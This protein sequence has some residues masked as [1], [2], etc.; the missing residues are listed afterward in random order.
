MNYRLDHIPKT[1]SCNR[2]SGL[3][4]TPTTIT[5]HNTGN[6][7]S[8][9]KNER[10]WLTNPENNRTASYHIVVDEH[11]A[12]E[13]IPLNE[14]AWHAGDGSNAAS[15]NRTSIAI[16]ICESGK[17]QQTLHNAAHLVAKM[18]L[19]RGWG[20]ERLRRHFDWSG[21]ICPRLMYD[22]GKWT[23][24]CSFIGMVKSYTSKNEEQTTREVL[25]AVDKLKKTVEEQNKRLKELEG[26]QEID[27]PTW[28]KEAADYYEKEMSNK[29]GSYDFWR[30]LTI[31]YRKKVIQHNEHGHS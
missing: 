24:W 5:I 9:A 15:G 31:Q 16:E 6:S 20:V 22:G 30:L 25:G 29:K 27:P 23:G 12:I 14:N 1:T 28:A 2:R 7:G 8:S 3:D 4:M 21:K 19:E 17:Y 26:Q 10:G 18:L 11:E 13:C